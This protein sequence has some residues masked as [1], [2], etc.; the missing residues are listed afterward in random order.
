MGIFRRVSDILSANVN[1]LI[2]EFEC[3]E[4]ML[5]QAVRE[6][7][8][9]IEKSMNAAAK[10]IANRNLLDKQLKEHRRRAAEWNARAA[11]AV[12]QSDDDRAR[13]ALARK[14]DNEK[15]AAALADHLAAA[16]ALSGRL[17]RRID[18]MRVRLA[19]A[20]QKQVML[21][22]RNRA[23]EARRKFHVNLGD[24]AFD[25]GASG[26]FDRMASRIE[27][28][29]AEADA[30]AELSDWD[31]ESDPGDVDSEIEA[32][33]ARLKVEVGQLPDAQ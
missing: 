15:L 32:E 23:A 3:P 4:T 13:R 16:D 22:A 11:A 6:M 21:I 33:L 25:T 30:F 31:E 1:E 29:E 19:E 2:D 26:R 18:A 17:R 14:A 24:A 5:K 20:R 27:Q 9:A 10:V 8:A 7:E 28:A 12:Q